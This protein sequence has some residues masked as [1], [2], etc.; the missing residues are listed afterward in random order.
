MKQSITYNT[1]S[2]HKIL[3]AILCAIPFV[4]TLTNCARESSPT[5]GP[6]DTIA[7]YAVFESPKNNS[8][9]IA[10]QKIVVKFNEFIALENV[11]DNCMISPML[12]EKP[13]ITV[14]KKKMTIDLSKQNL[15]PN[16]TYT[17]NFNGAI[18]DLSEENVTGQYI[19]AFSTGTGI[20]TM[21]I[22][23]KVSYAEN[24]KI[25]EHAYVL[26]YDNLSDTA[27]KTTKPRYI[28]QTSKKGEFSFLNIEAKPYKI[29][30]L[31]DSDKDYMFNQP[32]EK[33]AFLDTI[34]NPTAERFIDTV[35]FTHNDTIR[36]EDFEDSIQI[37]PVKDSF[38][39][40]EK[41]RWSDQNI[42]L[43]L[44]PN[45]VWEQSLQSNKRISKYAVAC[46]LAAKENKP[47]DVKFTVPGNYIT[48]YI[49]SDS[50]VFWL[51]DTSLMNSDS[52]KILLTYRVSKDSEKTNTDTIVVESTKDLAQRL[53]VNSS[54]EKN[55]KVFAGDSIYLTLSR[56][57]A[58][59]DFEK[60]KIYESCDTTKTGFEKL[61]LYNDYSYRPKYHYPE[62]V[63]LKYKETGERFAVYFAKAI[64]PQKVTVTLDGLPDIQDWYYCEYDEKSNAL[65][66][67][68][69]DNSNALRLKNLAITVQ[70]PLNN[71]TIATKNFNLK[72]DVAVQKLYKSA[73]SHKR[74]LVHLADEQKEQF[75]SY[76]PLRLICNNPI[77]TIVDS[78]FTLINPADS[79]ETSVITSISEAKNSS[80]IIEINHA[81]IDGEQ[82]VLT[83]KKGALVDTFASASKELTAELT[84]AQN[85][86]PIVFSVPFSI[87][88]TNSERTF[89]L[90][91]DW[92]TNTNYTLVIPDS[93]FTDTFG[94][95]NDSIAYTFQSPKK[96]GFGELQIKNNTGFPTNNLVFVIE[97]SESKDAQQFYASMK[98]GEIHFENIPAGNYSLRCFVDENNNEKWDSGCIETKR[99]PEKIYF[100]KEHITIKSEWKNSIF[101]DE[102]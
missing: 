44:F 11:D 96:E 97:S 4:F 46:K 2:T 87:H 78:L 60:I 65:L 5:G 14:K 45:E 15:Q 71:G 35:W 37:K 54:I 98:N 70:Y 10:P 95:A 25:P 21:R 91:A 75:R 59:K 73:T 42:Q 38:N 20:D 64:D 7:P 33:I 26:L 28:T 101:W 40:V 61:Q 8:Q 55:N 66:Y 29:Y 48:E 36:F 31:E 67:W 9:N 102:F 89:A 6:V 79:T 1:F 68:L 30:A 85:E 56:P 90:Y 13:N 49:S 24:G 81:A 86:N 43:S 94:D 19:Y 12:E 22:A 72:K 3:F 58:N 69:K 99:Q 47:T 62:Q 16:T 57:I 93:T 76:E 17:F 18:K 100:Y 92:N 39:L 74:L 80:R 51:T 23:G 84:V 53:M 34:F 63:A 88:N 52:A 41:T 27:F 32:S 83:L 50:L 77:Q 82:Y